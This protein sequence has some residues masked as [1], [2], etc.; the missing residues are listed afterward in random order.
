MLGLIRVYWRLIPDRWKSTCIFHETCS[1]YVY[2]IADSHG[3]RTGL[4]A[5]WKRSRQCRSGYSVENREG[6]LLVRLA[7][8]S[9]VEAER[10]APAVLRRSAAAMA[11]ELEHEMNA[12]AAR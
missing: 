6:K 9:C 2:R 4:T 3:F 10:I 7:D 12:F 1:H 5:L 8:D 11:L